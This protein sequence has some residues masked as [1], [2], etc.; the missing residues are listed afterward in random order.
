MEAFP[1]PKVSYSCIYLVVTRTAA[2]IPLLSA[3]MVGKKPV[4]LTLLLPLVSHFLKL[5]DFLLG[6]NA[7]L[8]S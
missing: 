7:Y 2:F 4:S 3:V 1:S 8:T 6:G 5:N